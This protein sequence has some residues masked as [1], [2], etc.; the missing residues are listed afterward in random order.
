MVCSLSV[1]GMALVSGVASQWVVWSVVASLSDGEAEPGALGH[2]VPSPHPGPK[3]SH[4]Q[5]RAN[6]W[7]A[8]RPWGD[9]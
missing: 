3:W 9:T 1:W 6:G 8:G 4:K 5:A 2:Q 7:V